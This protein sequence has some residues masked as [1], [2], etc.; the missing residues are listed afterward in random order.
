MSAAEQ[1]DTSD[2]GRVIAEKIRRL[3]DIDYTPVLGDIG[4][5][6]QLDSIRRIQSTKTDPSGQPWRPWSPAYAKSG[7]GRSLERRSGDLMG[8][9]DYFV[10]GRDE[11]TLEAAL[12]Y[13]ARQQFGFYGTDSLGRKVSHPARPYLGLSESAQQDV[14]NVVARHIVNVFN[15]AA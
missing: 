3:L 8:R 7:R 14:G 10:S 13:A 11:V 6:G 15:G 9:I 5:I 12:P 2:V 4:E 1:W